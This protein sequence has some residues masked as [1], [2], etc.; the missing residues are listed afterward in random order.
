L[1]LSLT[2]KQRI[3]AE[4]RLEG[5]TQKAAAAAAGSTD[6]FQLESSPTVQA[7]MLERMKAT[8]DEVDFGRREA[9]DML[10]DAYRNAET[11][12]EQIAAVNSLIKL[13]GLEK[14]KVVEHVHRAGAPRELEHM[15]LDQLMKL[16][17]MEDLILEGEFEEV[18]P[19]PVLGAPEVTDDNTAAEPEKVPTVSQDY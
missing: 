8:A 13:H 6:Y 2:Q 18:E 9:H 12:M 11:A 17:E 14:P 3:Y 10:M 4:A 19:V 7:Y 5:M 16:A 1:F 15:P